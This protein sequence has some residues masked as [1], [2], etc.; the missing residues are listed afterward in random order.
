[1]P[2][3]KT[4]LCHILHKK[5]TISIEM[6]S[7]NWTSQDRCDRTCNAGTHL[8][9]PYDRR[10]RTTTYFTSTGPEQEYSTSPLMTLTEFA[11]PC[12][13]Q[14]PPLCPFRIVI[15]HSILHSPSKHTSCC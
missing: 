4:L 10:H 15:L 9:S 13:N 8:F 14:L 11:S 6:G 5:A 2:H 7:S 1:V 12:S 3:R